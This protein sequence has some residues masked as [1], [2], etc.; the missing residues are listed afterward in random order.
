MCACVCCV[1]VGHCLT[2]KIGLFHCIIQ[3][4]L[5]F[6]SDAMLQKFH[7]C[8]I[9][10]IADIQTYILQKSTLY[11]V[12]VC[13]LETSFKH[14]TAL[15]F[16]AKK[17]NILKVLSAVVTVGYLIFAVYWKQSECNNQVFSHLMISVIASGTTDCILSVGLLMLFIYKIRRLIALAHSRTA[18]PAK[19][20]KKT[21]KKTKKII[22]IAKQHAKLVFTSVLS[23]WILSIIPILAAVLYIS[24]QKCDVTL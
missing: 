21:K 16:S 23:T 17:A 7:G 15:K 12:Y 11:W 18:T 3:I 19:I 14:H 4:L 24:V 6:F 5:L 10:K 2:K 22:R 8:A 20:P 1:C 9:V 13:L